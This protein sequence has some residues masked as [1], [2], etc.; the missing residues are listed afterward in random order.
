METNWNWNWKLIGFCF[1][2][3]ALFATAAGAQTI[4]KQI[5]ADGRVTFTDQPNPGAR[6]VASYETGRV[7][8]RAQPLAADFQAAPTTADSDPVGR[9]SA[10]GAG[11]TRNDV[12]RAVFSYASLDS[13]LASHVD[14]LEAARRARL[15]ASRDAK[16]AG[17]LLVTPVPRGHEPPPPQRAGTDILY[18]LWVAT[19][20][21]LAGG[22]LLVGWK[23]IR[24]ILRGLPH[25]Q[26]GAA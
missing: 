21:V 1:A 20:C 25:R 3:L 11:R 22:L 8:V 10:P 15:E 23:T 9:L 26:M 12:E 19:F 2:S 7:A 16:P 14:A 18:M 4:Y 13:S 5:D 6:V 17:V 24:M